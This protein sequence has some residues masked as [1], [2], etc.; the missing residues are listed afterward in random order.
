MK[1]KKIISAA[2]ITVSF[3]FSWLFI[4]QSKEVRLNPC[5]AY[6]VFYKNNEHFNALIEF[7]LF[8]K[9][10]TGVLTIS[11]TR[12]TDENRT[13][14]VRRAIEYSWDNEDGTYVFT[15]R[16]IRKSSR[17]ETL[18]DSTL[19]SFLPSFFSEVNGSLNLSVTPQGD[20]GYL[21]SSGVRPLF[22]CEKL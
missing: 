6:V 10:G 11:G 12:F 1:L 18:P 14:V 9:D 2:L 20:A 5:S 8:K 22:F 19:R 16:A 7:I 4:V 15:S 13:G 3:L 21:F 17:D